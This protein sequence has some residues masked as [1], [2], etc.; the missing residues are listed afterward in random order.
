LWQHEYSGLL[1]SGYT[2]TE[3]LCYLQNTFLAYT[4]KWLTP[5][6][7]QQNFPH[8]FLCSVP[9]P[10]G[11]IL[12]DVLTQ[13]QDY[14]KSLFGTAQKAIDFRVVASTTNERIRFWKAWTHFIAI[15]FPNYDEKLSAL[16]QPEKIDVLVCD[17]NNMFVGKQSKYHCGPSQRALNWTETRVRWLTRKENTIRKSANLLRAIAA[18]THPPSSN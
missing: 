15:Y 6:T 14:I 7:R 13:Q 5:Q 10:T 9:T 8:Q 4:T 11:R 2:L 17:A 16:S 12:D 1:L 18:K 3:R